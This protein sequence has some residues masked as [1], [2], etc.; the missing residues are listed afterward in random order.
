MKALVTGVYMD[1]D[2]GVRHGLAD[3]ILNPV[4]QLVGLFN[5]PLAGNYEMEIYEFHG[6]GFA[7]SEPVKTD[8]VPL[9]AGK[10]I[11]YFCLVLGGEPDI[12]NVSHGAH[13]EL[14]GRL[15]YEEGYR[16]RRYGIENG[17]FRYRYQPQAS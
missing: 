15:D 14:Y 9:M 2:L 7:A 11:P 3:L 17:D 1:N 6:T 12:K 5:R 16:N 8:A 4:A 13:C 10:D